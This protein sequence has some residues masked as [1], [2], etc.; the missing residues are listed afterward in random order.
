MPAIPPDRPP[1]QRCGALVLALVA[2]LGLTAAWLAFVHLDQAVV[3]LEKP[4]T[5]HPAWAV[6]LTIATWLGSWQ[7]APLLVVLVV[8]AARPHWRRM[9]STIAVA[10][11]LRTAVVQWMKLVIG[12]PRPRVLAD[13]AVFE[14]F[15]GGRSFPSGHASFAFMMAII[16][17]AWF[18]RWRWPAWIVASFV[19]VSRVLVDAHFISDILVGAVIGTVIGAVVLRAWPPVTEANRDSIERE[20]RL[21][22]E[23]RRSP[24]P[25]QRAA[26]RRMALRVLTVVLFVAVALLAYWFI[27]PIPG[28][29]DAAFFQHPWVVAMG[30]FGRHLGTWHLGPLLVALALIAGHD[31]WK[32]LLMTILAGFAVQTALT[33]GLKWLIGRPRPSQIADSTLFHGPGTDFH[34]LP[35]GHASFIFVFATICSTYFPRARV[36]LYALAVFVAASRVMLGAHYVSDVTAGALV[37]VL[38]A[39]IVLAIW[40]PRP[41]DEPRGA[42]R[43]RKRGCAIAEGASP[44]ETP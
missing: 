18:P 39:W 4:W 11:L 35:S 42:K 28:F 41:E 40:R 22:R 26:E 38:S 16:I 37:G 14:G 27:D 9:L 8:V 36:P 12:R 24:T 25:E 23:A 43:T 6:A 3:D 10:Y 30:R 1:A 15:G 29:F 13:A 44:E 19:A 2:V 5:A 17:S 34:S 32:R 7:L 33:E 31:R 21:R 20:E